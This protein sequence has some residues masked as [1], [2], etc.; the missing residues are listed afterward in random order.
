MNTPSIKTIA[1]GLNLDRDQAR[2]IKDLIS[3]K[4]EP[5]NVPSHCHYSH[6]IAA[7]LEACNTIGE[8]AGVEYIADK[9]DQDNYIDAYGLSYL[10]A[11]DTYTPTLIYDHAAG[12]YFVTSIGDILENPRHARRFE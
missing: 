9:R 6:K 11:G 1:E 10:N 4:T 12:R 7:I 3:G 5:E 8:F 2:Q